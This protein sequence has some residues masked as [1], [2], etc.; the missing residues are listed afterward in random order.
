M[1]NQLVTKTADK[2]DMLK[3]SLRAI[4]AVTVLMV[5]IRV[6]YHSCHTIIF[7][8]VLNGSR[9]TIA[10]TTARLR[11][12][13]QVQEAAG[14]R[15]APRDSQDTGVIYQA[16]PEEAQEIRDQIQ[17]RAKENPSRPPRYRILRRDGG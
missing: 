8:K 10:A 12:L 13:G 6:P 15:K 14:T 9:G 16:G 5:A 3:D 4:L 7:E 17:R 1:D 11:N 2:K